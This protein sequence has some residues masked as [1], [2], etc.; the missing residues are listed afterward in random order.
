MVI[1]PDT[2]A[3]LAR[4][5]MLSVGGVVSA[6]FTVTEI[7]ALA[8]LLAAS[9]AVA[10]MVWAPLAAVVLFHEQVYGDVVA[11]HFV[12]PSTANVTEATPTLS[13]ADAWIVIVPDTVA[14]LAGEV[15]L[16]VGGVVSVLLT[17]TEIEAAALL[18][19]ASFAVAVMVWTPLATKVL[20]QEQVYGDVVV[21]H[22][23][24]PSTAN[25][26]EATP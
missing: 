6:L 10:V 21:V 9:F 26:T 17:V 20:F 16:T 2:V 7:E 23:V 15:M 13:L 11:V 12:A 5:V 3:P 24:A 25:V 4:E 22:C 18:L 14:P 19:A 8:L 1:V